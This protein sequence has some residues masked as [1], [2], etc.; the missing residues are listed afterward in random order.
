MS[1]VNVDSIVW[2]DNFSDDLNPFCFLR[3][4]NPLEKIRVCT[5]FSVTSDQLFCS[6]FYCWQVLSVYLQQVITL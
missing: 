3:I 6:D 1:G 2:L 5:K 4:L